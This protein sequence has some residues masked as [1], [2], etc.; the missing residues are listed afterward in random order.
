MAR[1]D[2]I[3]KMKDVL[4]TRR[5]ALRLA[6]EGDFSLLQKM[7]Q[8][9]GDA[10]DF[11]Q[12]AANDEI[13]SQLAEVESREL[14]QIEIALQKFEEGSYG[15]CDHCNSNVSLA[16]IQALPYATLCIDCQRLREESGQPF[17]SNDGLDDLQMGDVDVN[18]S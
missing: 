17:P 16:R 8:T 9:V 6:L 4:V 15:K 5:K 14:A 12:G 10:V 7:E 13:S 2:S 3:K 11:A 1:A 18:V